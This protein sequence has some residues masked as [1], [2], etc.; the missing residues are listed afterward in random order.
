M[1]DGNIYGNR[2]IFDGTMESFIRIYGPHIV[3]TGN[4]ADY[5]LRVGNMG[6]GAVRDTV[7]VMGLPPLADLVWAPEPSAYWAGRHQ[8][9]WKLGEL[10]VGKRLLQARIRYHWGIPPPTHT[11]YE[12]RAAWG[13][14]NVGGNPFEVQDYLD[15]DPVVPG[16]I[17]ALEPSEITA[18]LSSHP[19]AAAL[20]Q[21]LQGQGYGFHNVTRS[22]VVDSA[23]TVTFFFL[24]HPTEPS[25]V[26]LNVVDLNAQRGWP[27]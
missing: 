20:L 19:Q 27:L 23:G 1:D 7:V 21:W 12:F 6:E 8:L 22:V 17:R 15:W 11:P 10:D 13:G 5:I 26:L 2:V 24:I 16:S 18:L 14:S 3:G 4:E 9:V 25:P